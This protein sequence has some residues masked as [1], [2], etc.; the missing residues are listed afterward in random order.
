MA[1]DLKAILGDSKSSIMSPAEIAQLG[2]RRKALKQQQENIEINRQDNML[3]TLENFANNADTTGEFNQLNSELTNLGQNIKNP[4]LKAR[5][6]LVSSIAQDNKSKYD[7]FQQTYNQFKDINQI[8]ENRLFGK[9]HSTDYGYL[10]VNDKTW[11]KASKDYYGK[12]VKDLTPEENIKMSARILFDNFEKDTTL[13][14]GGWNNWSAYKEGKHKPFLDKINDTSF[15]EFG[16]S[17]NIDDKTLTLIKKEFGDEANTALAVM[18]AESGGKSD[19]LKQNMVGDKDGMDS[20]WVDVNNYKKVSNAL[21]SKEYS[22]FLTTEQQQ[23]LQ[24]K[25]EHFAMVGESLITGG[26]IEPE[27]WEIISKGNYDMFK[28]Y[29]Q[30]RQNELK[31]NHETNLAAFNKL[32]ARLHELDTGTIGT[33]VFDAGMGSTVDEIKENI[34][35]DLYDLSNQLQHTSDQYEI[36]SGSS[37]PLGLAGLTGEDY[38]KGFTPSK[39]K[40]Y[41][42]ED[43]IDP[44]TGEPGVSKFEEE[45]LSVSLPVVDKTRLQ[46]NID[47]IENPTLRKKAERASK[48]M[49]KYGNKLQKFKDIESKLSVIKDKINIIEEE[50]K[51]LFKTGLYNKDEKITNR[52]N[53]L[54][55]D[56]KKLNDES[57]D[58][59]GMKRSPSGSKNLAKS[60]DN[61]ISSWWKQIHP[62]RMLKRN[63]KIL[64][65]AIGKDELVKSLPN[66]P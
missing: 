46:K 12:D 15:E 63:R 54:S 61:W 23:E 27:E 50:R 24:A 11:N 37:L 42:A 14:V 19:A 40:S 31:V 8:E 49:I 16:K 65:D 36:W 17:N 53:E 33:E 21:M 35:L 47:S 62:K 13:S 18:M 9:L 3:S 45:D 56:L 7:K 64:E 32:D 29:S 48:E 51:K 28:S 55:S 25:N 57:Y 4:E 60:I 41:K 2:L 6:N 22:R 1:I 43:Q 5:Y 58:V 66:L 20:L 59:R 26:Y 52:I 44:E 30:T 39:F 38:T 34:M 10:Q